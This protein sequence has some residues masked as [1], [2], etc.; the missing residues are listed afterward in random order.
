MPHLWRF[1]IVQSETT[2]FDQT[3]CGDRDNQYCDFH[4][5]PLLEYLVERASAALGKRMK[6]NAGPPAAARINPYET[7]SCHSKER[8]T[9]IEPDEA[10]LFIALGSREMRSAIESPPR[11]IS[12]IRLRSRQSAATGCAISRAP[13]R[14]SLRPLRQLQNR[15][16]ARCRRDAARLRDGFRR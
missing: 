6:G 1:G 12:D 2:R 10:R 15:T 11:G 9:S 7:R 13:S 8:I 4:G 14:S 3:T 16:R 5:I